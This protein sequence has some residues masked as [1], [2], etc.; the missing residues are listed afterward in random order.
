M[1]QARKFLTLD[2]LRGVAALTVVEFH[3][4]NF[5]GT[6]LVRH[7]Y[8]AVD[9][10][11]MLSGFVLTFAYQGRLDAGWSTG[12]FLKA[13]L[14]RLYP[15]YLLGLALGF[16]LRILDVLLGRPSP[17]LGAMVT[18]LGV[19][20]LLLPAPA[21][22]GHVSAFAF[23]FNIP[24]WSLF[25][26]LIANAVHALALRRRGC[27]F[28]GCLAGTAAFAFF[29][30]VAWR[31]EMDLGAHRT[32]VLPGL[33]RVLFGYTAGVLL[34]KVWQTGRFQWRVPPSLAAVALVLL[35][36]GP[37]RGWGHALGYD[38]VVTVFCFPLLLL[39]SARS[40]PPVRVARLFQGLGVASYAIYV[41]HVPLAAAYFALLAKL[42][43]R[44]RLQAFAPWETLGFLG[45]V[46][47]AALLTDRLYD[48]PVRR[49]LRVRW[50]GRAASR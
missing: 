39:L 9:F 18:L 7:G 28:L 24:A 36:I 11:F 20:L 25:F 1:D 4:A 14:I 48:S 6:R 27:R 19:G 12:A 5:A 45:M 35:L 49:V 21:Q 46:L 3:T 10:F 23:P 2:A 26:E 42:L 33:A 30:W 31:G 29:L 43:P 22:F 13:R 17:T 34:F 8:L 37:S 16:G 41:L 44:E 47:L 40:Q 15:L 38:M 32:E 50:S